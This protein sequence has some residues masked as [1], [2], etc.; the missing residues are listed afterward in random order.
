MD[1][2]PRQSPRLCH[3]MD[4]DSALRRGRHGLPAVNEVTS[5]L[6]V[7]ILLGED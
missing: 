7:G 4:A 6:Q 1:D 2:I 3:L 5:L